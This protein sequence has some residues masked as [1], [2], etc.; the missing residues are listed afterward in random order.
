M[1]FEFGTL[2]N[3][4]ESLMAQTI[5]FQNVTSDKF[6][7]T[8]INNGNITGIQWLASYAPEKCLEEGLWNWALEKGHVDIVERMFELGAGEYKMAERFARGNEDI[9]KIIKKYQSRNV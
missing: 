9:I 2:L 4:T 3:F 8:M 5:N 1:R 7:N 6:L